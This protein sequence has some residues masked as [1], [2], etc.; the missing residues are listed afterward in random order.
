MWWLPKVVRRYQVFSI[1]SVL[2]ILAACGGDDEP[3]PPAPELSVVEFATEAPQPTVI[4]TQAVEAT[5]AA[6]PAAAT[7][8]SPSS[9]TAV[10]I[11][12][13][14]G[15]NPLTGLNVD[16]PALL[17]RR[18]LMVRLGNDPIAR[19][20]VALNEADIVYEELVEWWVTRFTAIYL[21]NDPEMIA[22]IRSARLINL[23]LTPQ[24]QAAL[25]NSGGSDPVRWELS[26]TDIINLDEYFVPQPYFYRDNEGWQTR[27]AV[28]AKD[29]RNYLVEEG[30]EAPV[31]L[32]GFSFDEEPALPA[33]PDTVF[34]NAEEIAIPYPEKPARLP[35]SMMP[36]AAN[37]FGIPLITLSSILAGSRSAPLM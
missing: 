3:D 8:V 7:A 36:P 9:S 6:V 19:P 2:L 1:L 35:G 28:N 37:I 26:Q 17:Q 13:A 16:D 30:L 24:Y 4:A 12:R 22:P 29:A 34:G 10:D 5:A 11:I 20:Q 27:L 14:A 25:A 32:R 18:P 15:E 33:L 23:Q 21:A 31:N